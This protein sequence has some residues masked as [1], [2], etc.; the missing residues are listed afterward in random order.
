MSHA[1]YQ[2]SVKL[3]LMDGDKLL[4]LTTPDNYIDFPGGR[5]DESEQDLD[6][7]QALVREVSEELGDDLR[8]EIANTAF[9]AYR[10]YIESGRTHHV[11]VVHYRATFVG[12]T[13]QLSDEHSHYE[14]VGP[15]SLVAQ[16]E[17]FASGDEY[18]RF[19]AYYA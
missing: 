11:M 18:R 8:Y 14:W 16:R 6:I 17:R 12:G 5:I 19:A 7:E 9:V 3:Q 10:P 4:T 13:I 2:V 15:A 1:L